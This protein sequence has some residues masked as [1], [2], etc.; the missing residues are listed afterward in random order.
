M[1]SLG[2]R[3]YWL[4]ILAIT[5]F[6]LLGIA[7]LAMPIQQVVALNSGA[8]MAVP[9]YQTIPPLPPIPPVTDVLCRGEMLDA[10]DQFGLVVKNE[11]CLTECLTVTVGIYPSN[12]I[13]ADFPITGAFEAFG[14]YRY[15]RVQDPDCSDPSCA[16]LVTAKFYYTP[17]TAS[18]Y[19]LWYWDSLASE[20]RRVNESMEVGSLAYPD[21]AWTSEA[22]YCDMSVPELADL[23]YGIVF[24]WGY[25]KT[26]V[27]PG[28]DCYLPIIFKEYSSG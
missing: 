12:P 7:F 9:L 20:W 22:F 28:E 11:S 26:G 25:T 13:T 6:T 4:V 19:R 5:W 8:P 24:A 15:M 16:H 14:G 1:E 27:L 10:Q 2:Q 18:Q 17:T 23:P 3:G 21:D